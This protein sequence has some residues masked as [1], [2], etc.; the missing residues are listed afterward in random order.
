VHCASLRSPRLGL[1]STWIQPTTSLGTHNTVLWYC[2][3]HFVTFQCG[4]QPGTH[5]SGWSWRMKFS[6]QTLFRF[7]HLLVTAAAEVLCTG[8]PRRVL[9]LQ[10]GK[11]KVPTAT[12]LPA[13]T[14]Y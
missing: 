11:A 7:G 1:N 12:P 6:L 9:F 5:G 14:V 13:H 2:V 8:P 4:D 3:I 10:H